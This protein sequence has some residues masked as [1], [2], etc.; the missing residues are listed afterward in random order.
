MLS[1][2][3][4]E[5]RII[6]EFVERANDG[7]KFER[8]DVQ[9]VRSAFMKYYQSGP[10]WRRWSPRR[11]PKRVAK[12]IVKKYPSKDKDTIERITVALQAYLIVMDSM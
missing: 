1:E 2:Y 12:Y 8:R 9:L 7:M 10:W 6:H 4:Q 3:I 5:L 11:N